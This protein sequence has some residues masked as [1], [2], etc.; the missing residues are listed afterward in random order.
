MKSASSISTLAPTFV[1]FL[2]WWVWPYCNQH[3]FFISTHSKALH[4][5]VKYIQWVIF[6]GENFCE[7]LERPLEIIFVVLNFVAIRS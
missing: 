6:V 4:V 1:V 7:N 2:Q 3:T 5:G